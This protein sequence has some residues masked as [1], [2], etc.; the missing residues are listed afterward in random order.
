L[1]SKIPAFWLDIYHFVIY[2]DW[3]KLAFF[4]IIHV[5]LAGEKGSELDGLKSSIP[6]WGSAE[7][8]G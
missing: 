4:S 7:G 6:H 2:S 1:Y 5:L 3:R 8:D